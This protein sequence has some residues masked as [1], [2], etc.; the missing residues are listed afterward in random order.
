[1]L[2][3]RQ[4]KMSKLQERESFNSENSLHFD[5]F[6]GR[7]S[8]HSEIINILDFLWDRKGTSSNNLVD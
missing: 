4:T 5:N 8:L 2:F 6:T 7:S 1:M 3:I